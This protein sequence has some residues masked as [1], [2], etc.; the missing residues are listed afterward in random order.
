MA[1]QQHHV[2]VYTPYFWNL[3][4]SLLFYI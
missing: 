4:Y 2:G 1:N 3:T